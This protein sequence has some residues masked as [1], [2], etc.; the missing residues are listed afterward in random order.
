MVAS[1]WISTCT[2]NFALPKKSSR[3]WRIALMYSTAP[4]RTRRASWSRRRMV[5][6]IGAPASAPAA[7]AGKHTVL[8]TVSR[9]LLFMSAPNPNTLWLTNDA[10]PGFALRAAAVHS[11]RARLVAARSRPLAR[12]IIRR[13]KGPRPAGCPAFPAGAAPS[14]SSARSESDPS[15]KSN[16]Q[17]THVSH[18]KRMVWETRPQC[19]N[20]SQNGYRSR[21]EISMLLSSPNS[22]CTCLHY[23][24]LFVAPH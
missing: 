3:P 5:N 4:R 1:S 20:F 23:V 22:N 6:A 17:A 14:A 13:A 19:D 7:P 15:R 18:G 24:C 2:K 10:V 21:R 12:P 8:Q 16:T 9:C 11:S